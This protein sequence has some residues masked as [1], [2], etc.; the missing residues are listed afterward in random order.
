MYT[1]QTPP[2]ETAALVV[3]ALRNRSECSEK[4]VDNSSAMCLARHY[5]VTSVHCLCWKRNKPPHAS[6]LREDN[7]SVFKW[8]REEWQ[9]KWNYLGYARTWKKLSGSNCACHVTKW[10]NKRSEIHFN[11]LQLIPPL[12]TAIRKLQ[13]RIE[14]RQIGSVF[15]LFCR[16]LLQFLG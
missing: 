10:P 2:N 12:R 14:L 4:R 9:F 3:R 6:P 16:S 5:L 7:A 13:T 8:R 15:I 1:R 11:F